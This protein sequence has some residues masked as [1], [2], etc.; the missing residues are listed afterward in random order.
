MSGISIIKINKIIEPR[1]KTFEEAIIDIAPIV[2]S[3]KQ[4]MLVDNWLDRVKEKHEVE[5]NNDV[6]D[7]IY[8]D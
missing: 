5:I 3:M 1:E 7:E 4:Q 6:I 8:E 2:Q